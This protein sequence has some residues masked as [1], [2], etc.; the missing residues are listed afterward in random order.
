MEQMLSG[1]LAIRVV[2]EMRE[3]D[4]T[5]RSSQSSMTTQRR[6]CQCDEF[7]VLAG[8]LAAQRGLVQ[9]AGA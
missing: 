7:V 4:P 9:I 8:A 5:D 2:T 3:S 6:C 1:T